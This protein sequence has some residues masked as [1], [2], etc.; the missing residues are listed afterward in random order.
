M[1]ETLASQVAAG[2]VIERP[3]SVVKELIEN[4]LD[5]GAKTIELEIR[6]GG[7]ALL[8]VKDDGCGMSPEDA[9]LCLER[10]ATSKIKAVDDL[11]T[12]HTHGFRGEALPSITS[13]SRFRLT[14]SQDNALPAT[15]IHIEGGTIRSISE[16]AR[17][18]GTTIEVKDLFY[19]V[20]ARRKF[21]KSQNTEFGHIEHQFKLS[22][23]GNPEVRYILKNEDQIKWD[24]RPTKDAR[25]RIAEFIGLELSKKLIPLTPTQV[26]QIELHGFLLPGSEARNTSKQQTIF[27][28]SRPIDDPV[29]RNAIRD[30]YR[31]HIQPGQFP[32]VWL[33]ISMPPHELDINVHPAKREVRFRHQTEIKYAV[34][35]TIASTLS[36]KRNPVSPPQFFQN[37]RTTE[38][39]SEHFESTQPAEPTPLAR[40]TTSTQKELTLTE[41]ARLANEEKPP[42]KSRSHSFTV[43]SLFKN[44]YWLCEDSEGLVIVDPKASRERITYDTLKRQLEASEVQAQKLLIPSV[45]ET[46]SRETPLIEENL[47][48]LEE[49]GFEISSLGK[50]TFQL[51]SVPNVLSSDLSEDSTSILKDLIDG[52]ELVRKK[53]MREL[54]HQS[55][56]HT[57]AQR[58]GR[59]QSSAIQYADS[60]LT[61][62]VNCSI[63]YCTAAG[64]PTMIHYSE[65]EIKKKF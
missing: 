1:P 37:S 24:L 21:L 13:V 6:K 22:A 7:S 32:I 14:T 9:R 25:L 33:W 19:N 18:I 55:M 17:S 56:L 2:E 42:A 61:E 50:D 23:L 58:S 27:I 16:S 51:L 20:P 11:N 10:N 54:P 34:S 5:A 12:L 40:W 36:P 41:T 35:E 30:G 59:T 46:D 60:L 64:R 63:P 31:G 15:Q 8:K 57:I 43:L 38:A 44:R 45:F 26:G 65:N 29:V 47:Q 49:M 28:N 39:S 53:T 52:L 3:S 4:S 62:L 48:L